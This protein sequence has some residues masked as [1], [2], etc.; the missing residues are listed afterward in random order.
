MKKRLAIALMIGA[1]LLIKAQVGINMSAPQA[2]LHVDGQKNTAPAVPASYYDDVVVTSLGNMGVGTKS[3]KTRLDMRSDDRQNA[4]GIGGTA[5]TASAAK[6]GALR[7]NSGTQDLSYSN[8]TVWTALAHKAPN[9]FVDAENPSKQS[10]TSG[11]QTIVTNWTKKT[12]VNG[13]FNAATGIFVA[14]KTGV[15]IVSFTFSLA[16][17][18]IANDSRY[19]TLIQTNS[20]SSATNKVFKCVGSYPGTNG[21]SNRVAG[22]CSGIFNLTQGDNIT[23]NLNQALGT[24][25]TLDA[26]ATLT[27]LSIFGL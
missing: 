25:K 23:V 21:L 14:S 4:I 5:Q 9:D 15:Y 22:N 27:S 16:S 12:D 2:I 17:G 1:G 11:T 19:E 7:Y 8:G 24:S 26:D 18:T 6:A 10:F 13:S 20:A 3:P